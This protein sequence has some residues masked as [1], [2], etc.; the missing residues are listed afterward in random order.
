MSKVKPFR[1]YLPHPDRAKLVSSP[2]YDVLSSNEA[3][4]LAKENNISFLRV[5]K[6][7]IDFSKNDEP[8]G[9][10]LHEHAASNLNEFIKDGILLNDKE[11]NFYIYQISMGEH[12]QTG[13]ICLVSVKEYNDSLI[14]KHE[15]TRPDK[16]DDRT[17]H[18]DVTNANT[19]PV[20]LTFRNDG[21]FQN[22]LSKVLIRKEDISFR[23]DNSTTH[24][25]W[26]IN[27]DL[28][29]QMIKSYFSTVPCLYIADGHHRAASASRV[30]KLRKDREL[31]KNNDVESSYFLS[32]I[33]P[34]DEVQILGYNR[35]ITDLAGLTVDQFILSVEEKFHIE[36]L[37]KAEAPSKI[38]CFTMYLNRTWYRLEA[39]NK[40]LSNDSTKG[41][42]AAI[43]QDHIF[44]P[45]LK[46]DDP[47]ISN[48]IDFVGGIR[49]LGELE[50]RCELDAKVAFALYPVTI[51][52]LL[53]VS[54][55]GKVMPPKSTWFEPKLRSGLVVRSLD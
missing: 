52:Q 18:I 49:G 31:E 4:S 11:E 43:L 1:G 12:I 8:K 20:F 42:D 35:V 40:I 48:R 32:A 2:P 39:K 15:Y 6:P 14:K 55:E 33:F 45:I 13:I 9:R 36:E 29:I 10:K 37:T 54:D 30:Q 23:A 17:C 53:K 41:L 51:E 44:E 46:I 5:I 22:M 26:K 27:D 3:R 16:E 7:E 25:I 34:H 50:R 28:N 24:S 21:E 38:S 47:R 19:G